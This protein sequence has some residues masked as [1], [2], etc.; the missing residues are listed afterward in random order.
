MCVYMTLNIIRLLFVFFCYCVCSTKVELKSTWLNHSIALFR[1]PRH[2]ILLKQQTLGSKC[3]SCLQKYIP[4]CSFVHIAIPPGIWVMRKKLNLF[5]LPFNCHSFEEYTE[6]TQTLLTKAKTTPDGIV[7]RLS[8]CAV[9]YCLLATQMCMHTEFASWLNPLPL[10]ARSPRMRLSQKVYFGLSWY[11]DRN[12]CYTRW[13][14][15]M[16][17]Y[18]K[19]L[20]KSVEIDVLFEVFDEMCW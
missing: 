20:L 14:S 16:R 9:R 7:N 18:M 17:F 19:I 6:Y 12:A 13:D 4:Y 10:H 5:C 11:H 8:C 15:I 1:M 3:E 2:S